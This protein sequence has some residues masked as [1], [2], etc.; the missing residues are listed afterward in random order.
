MEIAKEAE[1]SIISPV[2]NLVTAEQVKAA[3]GAGLFVLPWTPDTFEE[4]DRLIGLG[5]DGIITDD[6]AALIERLKRN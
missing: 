6:P 3:H 2:Y 5:V 4:W 1:A